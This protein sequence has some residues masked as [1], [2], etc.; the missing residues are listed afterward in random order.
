MSSGVLAFLGD[1]SIV[2]FSPVGVALHFLCI[3][4]L[5]ANGASVDA[6]SEDGG[7]ALMMAACGGHLRFVEVRL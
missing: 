7:T 6:A 3:K 5:L 1:N 4:V 2:R